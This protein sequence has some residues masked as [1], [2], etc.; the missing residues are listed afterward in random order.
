[1]RGAERCPTPG[2]CGCG[3]GHPR[4]KLGLRFLCSEE[5]GTMP[6]PGALCQTL[7]SLCMGEPLAA[8]AL[9]PWGPLGVCGALCD[10]QLWGRTWCAAALAACS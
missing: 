1:M 8:V 7:P 2:E 3:M 6:S 10:P 4:S 5:L 9:G